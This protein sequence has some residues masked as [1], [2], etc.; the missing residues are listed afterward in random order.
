MPDEISIDEIRAA[1]AKLRL[2]LNNA[3][4]EAVAIFKG[5]TGLEISDVNPLFHPVSVFGSS[6]KTEYKLTGCEITIELEL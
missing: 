2:N 6:N 4:V 5:E 1:K 3:I